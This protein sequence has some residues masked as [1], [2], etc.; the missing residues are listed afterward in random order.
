MYILLQA[1]WLCWPH[2]SHRTWNKWRNRYS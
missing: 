2:P 1:W